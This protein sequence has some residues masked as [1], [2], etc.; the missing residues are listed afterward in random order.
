MIGELSAIA[1][2]SQDVIIFKVDNAHILSVFKHDCG[3]AFS[4]D[5]SWSQSGLSDVDIL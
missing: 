1:Y 3:I 2:L 4:L 5:P